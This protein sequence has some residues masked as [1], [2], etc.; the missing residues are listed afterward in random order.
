[1]KA[2]RAIALA[3][4]GDEADSDADRLRADATAAEKRAADLPASA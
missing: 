3:A 4:V 2:Q 1:M